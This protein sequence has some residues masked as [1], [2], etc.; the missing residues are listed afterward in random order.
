MNCFNECLPIYPLRLQREWRYLTFTPPKKSR[1]VNGLAQIAQSNK[2]IPPG[3]RMLA[4]A[5][6]CCFIAV[7]LLFAASAA[8]ACAADTYV[9]DPKLLEAAT[10]EGE[11]ILYTTHIVDQIVRP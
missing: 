7:A 6:R 2:P 5:V 11:V 10:K 1:I 3:G 9:P 4:R 8:P